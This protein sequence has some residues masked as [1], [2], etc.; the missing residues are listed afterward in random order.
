MSAVTIQR[1]CPFTAL[2]RDGEETEGENNVETD[3]GL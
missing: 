1:V 2:S 3:K